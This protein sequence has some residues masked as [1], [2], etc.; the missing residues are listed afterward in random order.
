MEKI[1]DEILF[2]GK[3]LTLC[4]M[5]FRN[6]D[7]RTVEWE[8]VRRPAGDSSV[9]LMPLL[10]PSQRYVL[11][12]QFRPAV[13]GYVLG[14][15]AGISDESGG[16]S[17]TELREETGYTGRVIEQS[18]LLKTSAGVINE[19][20]RIFF[21]QIDENDPQNRDPRQ[22]LEDSEEIEVVLVPAAEIT[23]FLSREIEKGTIIGSGL[24]YIFCAGAWHNRVTG[25]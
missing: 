14:F 23:Q 2:K 21:V 1:R 10:V 9:I 13:N 4:R 22:A 25:K 3:W 11:I 19:S 12:K 17:L 18:P 6:P 24:W 16:H 15:P 20:S 8:C 7:G 5:T